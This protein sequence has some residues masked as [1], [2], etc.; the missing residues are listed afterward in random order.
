MSSIPYHNKFLTGY[1]SFNLCS[2][3]LPSYIT[4]SRN[5]SL[6]FI[7]KHSW[8]GTAEENGWVGIVVLTVRFRTSFAFEL[9]GVDTLCMFGWTLVSCAYS[10]DSPYVLTRNQCE[11]SMWQFLDE[12]V[13]ID[14][15]LAIQLLLNTLRGNSVKAY[16]GY[17][18]HR[19]LDMSIL[20]N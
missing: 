13:L 3:N 20:P 4:S 10:S 19:V 2:R 6:Y 9:N 5:L 1:R 17:P 15:Q 16:K 14:L 12:P 7:E 11:L 18:R 8:W